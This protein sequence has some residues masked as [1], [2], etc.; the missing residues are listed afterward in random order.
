MRCGRYEAEANSDGTFNVYGVEIFAEVKPGTRKGIKDG[1]SAD[2]VRAATNRAIRRQTE[3][4][5]FA[6]VHVE[7][8]GDSTKPVYA[9]LLRLTGT[10]SAPYES[11]MLETV[12][13]DILNIPADVFGRIATNSLPYRSVEIQSIDPPE[14]RSL[15]LLDTDVPH[16]RFPTLSVRMAAS[17]APQAEVYRSPSGL[18]RA[19]AFADNAA[20]AIFRFEDNP[21]NPAEQKAEK[22]AETTPETGAESAPPAE[23]KA[24]AAAAEKPETEA[25]GAGEAGAE[26][27]MEKAEA[28]QLARIED[29]LK[30][31]LDLLSPT[32]TSAAPMKPKTGAEP[33]EINEEAASMSADKPTN[34]AKPEAPAAPATP[35]TTATTTDDALK[36]ADLA[37][38]NA[39]LKADAASRDAADALRTRIDGALA[40]LTGYNVTDDTRKDIAHFAAMGDEALNRFVAS[41]SRTAPKDGPRTLAELEAASSVAADPAEVLR[42]GA[43]GMPGD[44]IS[45][46]REA[47]T[48]WEQ[49]RHLRGAPSLA[50]FLTHHPKTREFAAS[51]PA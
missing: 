25:E 35:A 23:Q 27:E 28:A 1:L 45:A 5:Y 2:W 18:L 13:A 29:M 48:E 44:A 49:I 20:A 40:K 43:A 7:H 24:E 15:A 42:F 41:F 50:S 33:G 36:F 4:S 17:S 21:M 32:N 51:L 10:R 39:R 46:A 6:P 16:F 47:R 37:G 22:A 31:L 19:C 12:F 9:G 30:K 8:N 14:F 34:E 3:D 26:M 38:E 11:E